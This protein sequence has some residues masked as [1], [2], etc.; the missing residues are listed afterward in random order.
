[1]RRFRRQ[2]QTLCTLG[3]FIYRD[4]DAARLAAKEVG[5]GIERCTDHWHLTPRETP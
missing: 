3:R 5:A 4:R 1:M 2:R